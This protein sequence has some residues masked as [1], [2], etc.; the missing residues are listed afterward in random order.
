MTL[1]D[2]LDA[3]QREHSPATQHSASHRTHCMVDDRQQTLAAL[4]HRLYEFQA[5][6]RKL[7]KTHILVLLYLLD[8]A[9]MRDTS[10]LS[11]LQ[12]EQ[13]SASRH[14]AILQMFYAKALKVLSA[15]MSE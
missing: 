1:V 6:H 9:D 15:K 11:L 8:I 13:H 5:S 3:L 7:V 14:N 2:L 4:I 10:V 12:I